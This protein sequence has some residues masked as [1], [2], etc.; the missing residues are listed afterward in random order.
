MRAARSR[1][2]RS[3]RDSRGAD[4]ALTIDAA[5]AAETIVDAMIRRLAPERNDE[6]AD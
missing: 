4:G 6:R 2:R 3:A 1:S 5:Q